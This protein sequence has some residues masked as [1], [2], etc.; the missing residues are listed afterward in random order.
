VVIIVSANPSAK[1]KQKADRDS[2]VDYAFVNSFACVGVE[3]AVLNGSCLFEECHLL[4]TSRNE[5]CALVRVLSSEV[6]ADCT[7]L[8]ENEAV[9]ILDAIIVVP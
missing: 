6:S 1:N 3:Y 8:G 7:A 2:R 4:D 5:N 9:V